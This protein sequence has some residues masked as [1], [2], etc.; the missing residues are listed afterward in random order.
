MTP[1]LLIL[2]GTMEATALARAVAEAGI[3]GT[4]SFAGRVARP[5]RQPLPQRVGGFGGVAGL[6]AFLAEAGITHVVDA[7]HPFAAQMSRNA[8][9]AC[10]EA[11]V[12]LIALTRPPWVPQPGDDW[13]R[14]PDIAGAVAA[15]DQPARR[16]MLAVGRMHLADFAPNPQHFYLLRLVD[17]PKEALPLPNAEVVVSRG[18]FTEADDRALM[19]R[20]GIDLVVS[21]N[22]GG[23]GAY[24]KIAAARALSLPVIMIDRP[25][26]P[27]RP[28]V[29][30][31]EEVLD[32]LGHPA[33]VTERG[34]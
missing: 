19:E 9:E 34:V 15:L 5:V 30:T 27:P 4:V 11:R 1:N 10:A 21:K 22:A 3:A 28:E 17:P 32:W 23:K 16:V 7:T 26:I 31:P 8:I 25:A 12:P 14:V 24:A 18:P 6:R 2:G 13:Q 29:A 33:S 20:H